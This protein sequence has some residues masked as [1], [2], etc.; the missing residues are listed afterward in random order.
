MEV[1][2]SFCWQCGKKLQRV[3][4]KLVFRE[5]TPKG[6]ADPVRIHVACAKNLGEP[7]PS[8][9]SSKIKQDVRKYLRPSHD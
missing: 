4:G 2:A 8:Y 9:A 5:A 1:S 6:C 7:E 3:N